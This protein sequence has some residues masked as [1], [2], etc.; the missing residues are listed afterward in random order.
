MS[1]TEKKT[2]WPMIAV[3]L[4]LIAAAAFGFGILFGRSQTA[5]APQ[6]AATSS[7][8]AVNVV[9]SVDATP[10]PSTAP[11]P[12]TPIPEKPTDP[13]ATPVVV[14]KPVEI[15][16]KHEFWQDAD[17]KMALW[18]NQSTGSIDF[19]YNDEVF[20]V[21]QTLQDFEDTID[22]FYMNSSLIMEATNGGYEASAGLYCFQ[23]GPDEYIQAWFGED[24]V[25]LRPVETNPFAK[26]AQ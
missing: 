2:P 15:I 21:T 20:T 13:P 12:P 25:I 1:N 19:L 14:L 5:A 24:K 3:A 18:V 8:S 22:G 17:G 7:G 16:N 9:G 4:C 6:P 23:D 26:F 10:K 11:A